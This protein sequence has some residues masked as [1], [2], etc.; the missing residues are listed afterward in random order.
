MTI[1]TLKEQVYTCI[2][3]RLEEEACFVIKRSDLA[4]QFQVSGHKISRVMLLLQDEKLIELRY[5]HPE[6]KKGAWIIARPG[7]GTEEPRTPFHRYA[8]VDAPDVS[9][10]A[11]RMLT[12]LR[13]TLG[14]TS[15]I[16]NMTNLRIELGREHKM[17]NRCFDELHHA[18]YITLTLVQ[19]KDKGGPPRKEITV[20]AERVQRENK[21][22]R[23]PKTGQRIPEVTPAPPE[24]PATLQT[25]LTR[26]NKNEEEE[27]QLYRKPYRSTAELERLQ[28][29]RKERADLD[30]RI[31]E[32]RA[33]RRGVAV[34]G[35][36]HMDAA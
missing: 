2:Q 18:G 33:R 22:Y 10:N 24:P 25:L 5:E 27:Q 14:Y 8:E 1:N 6:K 19:L 11:R 15:A 7:A 29:L 32:A 21:M 4:R 17:I 26:R 12:Y 13:S 9:S 28:T 31:R 23:G 16:I 20:H 35:A 30:Q 34:I 3:P 36:V